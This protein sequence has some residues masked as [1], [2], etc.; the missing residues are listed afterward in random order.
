MRPGSRRFAP[1]GWAVVLY[2]AVLAAMLSLGRWQ[3][4][5]ADEKI[6]L[7]ESA[8][9]AR[10]RPAVV[11]EDVNDIDGAAAEHR[12]VVAR[13]TWDGARQLLWD[14]RA[15][16][17]RAGYEAIAPLRLA[18]GRLA[19][20]NRGWVAPGPTRAELP[21]VSLADGIGAAEVEIEGLLSRPSKGFASGEALSMTGPW[22]RV[23]QYFD[24]AA[25]E[26]AL[27]EPIVPAVVQ[28]QVAADTGVFADA[29]PPA[30]PGVDGRAAVE[31]GA[32][33]A[34]SAT[35]T[36][37]PPVAPPAASTAA[38]LVPNWRPAASGPEKHYGYAFQWFAMAA[39]LTVIFVVVNLSR[40]ESDE[41]DPSP[42]L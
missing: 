10:A 18:D 39:A 40:N 17:G 41:P 31:A 14:N 36:P 23:L 37:V 2:V 29:A 30:D 24:Y 35:S 20:V 19:L 9:R 25:I 15:H 7:L 27:G 34:R 33:A 12:R 22:P 8:E 32:A 16:A 3:L 28:A 42:D 21:D 11:L 5:R 13:G 1:R 38:L 26:A 4:G 6:A